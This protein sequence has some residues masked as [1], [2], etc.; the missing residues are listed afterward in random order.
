MDSNLKHVLANS[1]NWAIIPVRKGSKGIKDK[2]IQ[3]IAGK[4]LLVRAIESAK[5]AKH[6]DR[7]F[8]STDSTEYADIARNHQ[9]EVPFL[10][11]PELAQD[12]S[13]TIDVIDHFI[14]EMHSQNDQF[15]KNILLIQV[16]C[17]FLNADDIDQS[18]ALLDKNSDAVCSVCE[19]EIYPEWLRRENDNGHLVNLN[20]KTE[21][22]HQAR[23]TFKTT[24][25]V[26]GGLYWVKCD[27]FMDQ[28]TFIPE[29]TCPYI[30]SQE[31]SID[32]DT[33]LDLEFARFMAAKFMATK[34]CNQRSIEV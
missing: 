33:P 5:K 7:V 32:I 34:Q 13:S 25:R 9:A 31:R 23:Q 30:M 4:S 3:D 12:N 11:P 18:Y 10:R 8:V 24:Y 17:P 28:N 16:T 20:Y 27:I 1:D 29:R 21:N 26:N 15:P 22:N 6:V 19:S 14:T 2:C